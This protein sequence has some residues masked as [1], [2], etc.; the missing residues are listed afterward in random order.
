[1]ETLGKAKRVR[2]RAHHARARP[3]AIRSLMQRLPF[4][5]P[6]AEPAAAH[7]RGR[8]AAD[9]MTQAFASVGEDVLLST[10]IAAMLRGN[11]KVLAVTDDA[12][13][14][15]GVVD[16]ADLLHGLWSTG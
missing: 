5:H 14:L 11:H 1:M 16:R 12:E 13:R 8:T 3:G 10:A 7:V 6:K 9:L 4:A 2:A 15:V